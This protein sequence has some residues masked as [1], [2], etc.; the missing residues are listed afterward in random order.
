MVKGPSRVTRSPAKL[1]NDA[2]RTT[3]LAERRAE[4]K[5]CGSLHD[6]GVRTT[7]EEAEADD[8]VLDYVPNRS[9]TYRAPTLEE[10]GESPDITP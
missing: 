2:R 4:P 7:Q 5:G 6:I 1:L 8:E 3:A 10:I 9:S